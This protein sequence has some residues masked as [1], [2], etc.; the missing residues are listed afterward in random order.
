MSSKS[1]TTCRGGSQKFWEETLGPAR[2]RTRDH[3]VGWLDAF[4]PLPRG[5]ISSLGEGRPAR[6][7]HHPSPPFLAF[8]CWPI[9]NCYIYFASGLRS[10]LTTPEGLL[11]GPP[12]GL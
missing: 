4:R 1:F 11:R 8:L 12:L 2:Y 10:V 9:V 7:D 5:L 3:K 6:Q